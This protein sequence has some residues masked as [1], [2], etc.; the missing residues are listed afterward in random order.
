MG[1]WKEKLSQLEMQGHDI[2]LGIPWLQKHNP[3]ADWPTGKLVLQQHGEK[4]ELTQS[5]EKSTQP[6]TNQF[7]SAMQLKH[8]VANGERVYLA[9]ITTVETD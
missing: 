8:C 7:L 5:A 4:S 2:I 3:D 1:G 9:I 6:K